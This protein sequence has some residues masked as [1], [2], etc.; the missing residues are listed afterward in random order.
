[1]GGKSLE[2]FQECELFIKMW[3]DKYLKTYLNNVLL[4]ERTL[5][6]NLKDKCCKKGSRVLTSCAVTYTYF[7]DYTH[8][9]NTY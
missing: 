3:I 8:I 5:H 9:T 4:K 7:S 1:M 6:K 2:T